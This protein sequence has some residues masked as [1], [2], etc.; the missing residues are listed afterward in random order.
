MS[1]YPNVN[2]LSIKQCTFK[3]EYI[4]DVKR[5]AHCYTRDSKAF[6]YLDAADTYCSALGKKKYTIPKHFRKWKIRHNIKKYNIDTSVEDVYLG[7]VLISVAY[8]AAANGRELREEAERKRDMEL[9]S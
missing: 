3:P 2:E 9:R 5:Y 6:D 8:V 7:A 1:K 4:P